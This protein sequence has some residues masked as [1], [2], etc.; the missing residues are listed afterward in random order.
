MLTLKIR[1]RDE[2]VSPTRTT[3]KTQ[4][5]GAPQLMVGC[6][7]IDV[8][9]SVAVWVAFFVL[10][11]VSLTVTVFFKRVAVSCRVSVMVGELSVLVLTTAG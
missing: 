5:G 10:V 6:C 3:Y 11:W 4:P 1:L 8:W 9:V 2:S 7:G